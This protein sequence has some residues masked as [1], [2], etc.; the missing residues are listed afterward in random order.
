MTTSDDA[1]AELLSNVVNCDLDFCLIWDDWW[2]KLIDDY[3]NTIT[4]RLTDRRTD[5]AKSR[6][7]FE[8]EKDSRYFII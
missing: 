7:A 8:T 2:L 6:G 5:N 1:L 3:I 4:D